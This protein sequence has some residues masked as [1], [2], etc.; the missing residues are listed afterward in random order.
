MLMSEVSY[1]Y[2]DSNTR[3]YSN[4]V[5]ILLNYYTFIQNLYFT[6][7]T[8]YFYLLH[9]ESNAGDNDFEKLI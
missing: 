9:L 6:S 1:I 7:E 3:V 8:E 2:S 4:E 5:I